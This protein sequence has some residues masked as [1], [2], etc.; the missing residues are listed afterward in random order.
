MTLPIN[1]NKVFICAY[2][3][4]HTFFLLSLLAVG[5]DGFNNS[6]RKSSSKQ[7]QKKRTKAQRRQSEEQD[8]TQAVTP[9]EK[10]G[11]PGIRRNLSVCSDRSGLSEDDGLA[12][13]I[14]EMQKQ[15]AAEEKVKIDAVQ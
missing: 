2:H 14:E 11:A 12:E 7:Q 1:L 13:I 15:Q 4:C 10:Q 9:T 3:R 8:K 6:G 5:E